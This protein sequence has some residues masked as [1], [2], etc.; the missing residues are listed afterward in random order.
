[1]VPFPDTQESSEGHLCI[2]NPAGPFVD[3]DVVD[4]AKPFTCG[5]VNTCASDLAS[6]NETSGL[7][8]LFHLIDILFW[9]TLMEEQLADQRVPLGDRFPPLV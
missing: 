4:L 2:S 7:V 6:R 9:E 5:V 1:M 3:D 8:D